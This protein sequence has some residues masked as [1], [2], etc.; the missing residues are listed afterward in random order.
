MLVRI[1]DT[2]KYN[3]TGADL[4]TSWRAPGYNDASWPANVALFYVENAALPAPKNT[5]LT[6]G[7]TTFYFRKKFSFTGQPAT[8]T[9]KL[10]TVIDDAAIVYLNGVEVLRLGM[11]SGDVSSSTFA[12][13]TVGDAAYEGPFVISSASLVSGE[14]T[15]AVEVHQVNATS[16]DVVFGLTLEAESNAGA[17]YTPGAGNSVAASLPLPLLWLNEVQPNNLTGPQDAA[18][19]RDP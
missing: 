5:P 1:D 7:P 12:A 15:L 14:N 6:L 16:S 17:P 19:D 9:L 10:S 13:R 3:Q 2:W 18:G 11:P 8:T 4:G